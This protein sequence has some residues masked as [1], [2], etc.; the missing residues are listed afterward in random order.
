MTIGVQ[1][2]TLLNEAGE[3]IEFDFA[4][5]EESDD[6]NKKAHIIGYKGN[7]EIWAKRMTAQDVVDLARFNQTELVALCGH[8]FTPKHNPEKHDICE[9][10]R[11]LWG[12]M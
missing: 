1:E 12:A 5:Y 8:K 11:N 2:I 4:P 7:E 6:P 10:C 3:E 9:S